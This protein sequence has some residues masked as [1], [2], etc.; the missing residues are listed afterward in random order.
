[1]RRPHTFIIAVL[2]AALTS[3]SACGGGD[4]TDATAVDPNLPAA[5]TLLPAAAARMRQVTSAAFDI[6]TDGDTGAL[7]IT[8][9]KGAIDA[10]GTAQG[11]ATLEQVGMPIELTFVAKDDYLYVKGLTAGWQKVPLA[12]AAAVYD[13]TAILDPAKGIGAVLA[14]ATG[15]TKRKE[16]LDGTDHYVVDATFDGAAMSGLVPGVTGD[17]TGTVWIG[18]DTPLV[19]Q[20]RF[21]VPGD[22]KGTV[23][24]KFGDFDKPVNVDVPKV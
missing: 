2:L 9:A 11:T 13:P 23:L 19:N 3:V 5:S 15:T 22:G 21:T 1:M 8:S 6:T 7:P 12:Q 4:S 24:I 14:S 20:L 18:V 10:K 17:V 16:K